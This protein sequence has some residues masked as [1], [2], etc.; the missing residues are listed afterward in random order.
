MC[1]F[2]ADM[3]RFRTAGDR[4]FTWL[5]EAFWPKG[6]HFPFDSYC[7][8]RFC[9]HMTKLTILE[10]GC[11]RQH[12]GE[13]I[14]ITNFKLVHT[15]YSFLFAC[16][17]P[18]VNKGSVE[19]KTSSDVFPFCSCFSWNPMSDAFNSRTDQDYPGKKSTNNSKIMQISRA[20]WFACT[21]G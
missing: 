19:E 21:S 8:G 5:L 4:K 17:N 7:T 18:W 14:Y 2:L 9:S 11:H 12:Q 13:S 6:K 15:I 10:T 3:N 1:G 16:S 20:I